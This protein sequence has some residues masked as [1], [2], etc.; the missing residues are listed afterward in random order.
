M[1]HHIPCGSG[2]LRCWYEVEIIPHSFPLDSWLD[3]HNAHVSWWIR[4]CGYAPQGSV[5]PSLKGSECF[6]LLPGLQVLP[7]KGI[8]A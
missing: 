3:L 1:D 4:R 8:V 6:F 2:S 5:H 7:F